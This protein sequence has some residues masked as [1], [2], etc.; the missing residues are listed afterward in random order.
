MAKLSILKEFFQFI[1]EEKKWWL[2]P[3]ILIL[4]LMIVFITLVESS[5]IMPFIYA[6]F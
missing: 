4:V 6:I 2:T 5:A 3:I 1:R